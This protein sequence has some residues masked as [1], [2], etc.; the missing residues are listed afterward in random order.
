M[1]RFTDL[2]I[3]RDGAWISDAIASNEGKLHRK[4]KRRFRE[5]CSIASPLKDPGRDQSSRAD[6][7]L[8]ILCLTPLTV[9]SNLWQ[10]DCENITIPASLQFGVVSP[11]VHSWLRLL[12]VLTM[13][14]RSFHGNR[15]PPKAT[16]TERSK[17]HTFKFRGL[18]GRCLPLWLAQT[19]DFSCFK[20]SWQV[21]QTQD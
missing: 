4:K 3:L 6:R 11:V 7:T 14:V 8:L 12:P 20:L 17:M 18:P 5:Y 1:L 15:V 10:T 16:V 2:E 19:D 13:I 9:S 21:P